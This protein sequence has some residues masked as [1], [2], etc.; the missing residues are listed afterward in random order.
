[1]EVVVGGFFFL[2][3]QP[4]SNQHCVSVPPLLR[5]TYPPSPTAT[6]LLTAPLTN[7]HPASS[8]LPRTPLV[9]WMS[10]DSPP[11]ENTHIP[12][13]MGKS[14]QSSLFHT[15]DPCCEMTVDCKSPPPTP[16]PLLKS[17]LWHFTAFDRDGAD[18]QNPPDNMPGL[19][20]HSKGFRG[21]TGELTLSLTKGEMKLR[22]R[23][24]QK[25]SSPPAFGGCQW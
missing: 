22:H 15:G 6:K 16:R 13:R 20:A 5:H 19:S 1:M 23:S 8:R 14:R 9:C 10:F 11:V 24:T 3:S 17:H 12:L 18:K 4:S 2:S 7:H 21:K 25:A